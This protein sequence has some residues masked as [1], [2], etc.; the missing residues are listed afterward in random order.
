MTDA[1]APS[2]MD[3]RF[4][5]FRITQLNA[6]RIENFRRNP[7]PAD[8]QQQREQL[9]ENASRLFR[10]LG[11]ADNAVVKRERRRQIREVLNAMRQLDQF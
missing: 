5:G 7:M 2:G 9:I 8:M 11:N 3:H 1:A 10:N 6:R 4:L